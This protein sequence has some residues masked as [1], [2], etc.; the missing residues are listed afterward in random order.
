M[1][2]LRGVVLLTSL[3]T[4]CI[5]FWHGHHTFGVIIGGFSLFFFIYYFIL[6]GKAFFFPF[7]YYLGFWCELECG[8]GQF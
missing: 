8:R 3:S 4:I 5:V 2:G 7:D 6:F 1:R